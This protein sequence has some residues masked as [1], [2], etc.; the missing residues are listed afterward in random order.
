MKLQLLI[1]NRYYLTFAITCIVWIA[2]FGG[3]ILSKQGVL[4]TGKEVI[5]EP[6]PVDPRD[7]FRGE[8]VT[9]SYDISRIAIST[10]GLPSNSFK[11]G[12]DVYVL[13]SPDSTGVYRAA[14]L[15]KAKPNYPVF[16]KGTVTYA[17]LNQIN[18]E[19]GIE[20]YFVEKNTS[21]TLQ[22][23]I[24]RKTILIKVVIDGSGNAVIKELI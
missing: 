7:L 9:F 11:S 5:L 13:L 10:Y 3:F 12:D 15:S 17:Y 1:K 6:I 2:I 21:S 18:V 19:Y 14:G 24:V 23:G 22:Q 4:M 20:S 16:I 8:Y